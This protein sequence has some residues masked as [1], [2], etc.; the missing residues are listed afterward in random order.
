MVIEVGEKEK[1]RIKIQ[2][3]IYNSLNK[4][5]ESFC[6]AAEMYPSEVIRSALEQFLK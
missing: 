1:G 4:S 3:R 5:L 2:G 6:A